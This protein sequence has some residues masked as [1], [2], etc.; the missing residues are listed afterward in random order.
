MR[1]IVVGAG[2]FGASAAY[3][4]ALAGAEVVIVD[5]MLQGRATAAGAG[6]ICPWASA[7][8]EWG[9]YALSSAGARYYPQLIDR[10]AED[11]ETDTSYRRVGAMIVSAD[12]AEMDQAERRTRAR[13][14]QSPEAGSIERIGAREAQALFPP[15]RD[16][17]DAIHISGGARVDG[18]KLAAAL[19]RAAER[20]GATRED[21]AATLVMGSGKL[22]G[23]AIADRIIEA[24]QVVVAA[25]AW[26]PALLAPLGLSLAVEPQRGQIVHLGSAGTDTSRWPV[27]LP[28]SSHYLLAFDDSRV[29]VGASRE[30]GSGFDYKVTAGGLAQVLEAALSVAPGLA[31][32]EHLETRIG[33]RPMGPGLTPMLGRIPGLDGLVIGNGLGAGGLTMGPNAGRLLAEITLGHDPGID[34]S[35]YDPLRR[36]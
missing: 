30:T 16:G 20:H 25:G 19:A 3:H 7:V 27:L 36:G 2:V 24:D 13:A 32:F 5:P 12:A 10:L 1:A 6:I 26:A 28:M 14:A 23:V 4:L 34:L 11:G 21:G 29:V 8:E 15:L 17:Q 33:F 9:H 22:R 35:P 18:R 31:T